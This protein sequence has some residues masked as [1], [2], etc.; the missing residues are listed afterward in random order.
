MQHRVTGMLLVTLVEVRPAFG[1]RAG[2]F[3]STAQP[4]AYVL[5]GPETRV[6]G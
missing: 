1:D 3:T 6:N 5:R 2:D 4:V